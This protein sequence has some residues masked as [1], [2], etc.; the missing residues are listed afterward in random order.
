MADGFLGSFGAQ[1]SSLSLFQFSGRFGTMRRD[2]IKRFIDSYSLEFGIS[3]LR[4]TVAGD[5]RKSRSFRRFVSINSN[6]DLLIDD[7]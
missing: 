2:E 6:I 5:T 4:E 7:F 1:I 3:F